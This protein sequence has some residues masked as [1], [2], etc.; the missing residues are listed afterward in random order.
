M[1]RLARDLVTESIVIKLGDRLHREGEEHRGIYLQWPGERHHLDFTDLVGRSVWVY[2]QT[3]L[4]R[5][6]MRSYVAAPMR[7][8]QLFLAGD[9]AHTVPPT[10]AKGLNLAVADVCRARASARHD[11]AQERH[12]PGRLLL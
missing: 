8:G 6:P 2:G 7:Y 9:A 3:E 12:N 10:G 1:P 11:A 5:D 4:T